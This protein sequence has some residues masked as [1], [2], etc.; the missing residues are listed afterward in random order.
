[1]LLFML[2]FCL[3]TVACKN[4]LV[5][6][7]KI[8]LKVTLLF[9]LFQHLVFRIKGGHR[10]KLYKNLVLRKIFGPNRDEVTGE[11]RKLYHE[12]LHDQYSSPN[13]V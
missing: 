13:I 6:F 9:I 4:Q 3:I 5:L 8:N 2:Y 10:L 1:M 7:Y 11:L 12:K